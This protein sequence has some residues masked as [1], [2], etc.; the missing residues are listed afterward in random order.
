MQLPLKKKK[1]KKVH[2]IWSGFATVLAAVKANICFII[3]GE[4]VDHQF[5]IPYASTAHLW[6]LTKKKSG[7]TVYSQAETR[8]W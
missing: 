5:L 8:W 1:K 6:F 2:I 7:K 4:A 3:P